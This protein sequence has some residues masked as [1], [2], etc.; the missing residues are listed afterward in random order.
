MLEQGGMTPYEALRS[1]TIHGA[2]YLGMDGDIGSL[3]PGK[4]ADLAIIDGNPLEDLRL[5]E[6][7]SHTIL[8]GRIYDAA[9]MDQQWPD[10]V[11][12]APLSWESSR[13]KV[14]PAV[15]SGH[16]CGCGRH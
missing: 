16:S 8:G 12:R 5:S 1:A 10:V 11:E 14:D 2:H 13:G 7:V 3:A 6:A 15:A 4:L 9:T